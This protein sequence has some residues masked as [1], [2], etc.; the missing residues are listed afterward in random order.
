MNEEHDCEVLE[1]GGSSELYG[2]YIS[3]AAIVIFL[4]VML[5]W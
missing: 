1:T 4:F 3:L 5:T 2:L